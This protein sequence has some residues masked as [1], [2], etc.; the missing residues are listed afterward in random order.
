MGGFDF[1]GGT[2]SIP[3]VGRAGQYHPITG[4]GP[5]RRRP[6]GG[7]AAVLPDRA[8]PAGSWC[9]FSAVGPPRRCGAAACIVKSLAVNLKPAVCRG[10]ALQS[11]S[12]R[13]RDA[14]RPESRRRAAAGP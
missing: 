12:R 9:K 6:G 1:L 4:P 8:G 11:E 7:Q 10:P 13:P 5:S 3:A 14:A 2:T